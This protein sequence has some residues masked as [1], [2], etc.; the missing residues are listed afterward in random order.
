MQSGD[1]SFPPLESNEN[2]SAGKT[3]APTGQLARKPQP[4][5]VIG[6]GEVTLTFPRWETSMIMQRFNLQTTVAKIGQ[7][8]WGQSLFALRATAAWYVA[9][10]PSPRSIKAST[11]SQ[12]MAA[13]QAL[14]AAVREMTSAWEDRNEKLLLD[15]MSTFY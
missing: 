4:Y 2:G 8:S 13:A 14:M 15:E 11:A 5:R 7:F 12:R 6:F 1:A 9:S 3:H 10:F